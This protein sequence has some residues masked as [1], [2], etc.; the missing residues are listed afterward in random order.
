[1]Y[2]FLLTIIFLFLSIYLN[3]N[4][5]KINNKLLLFTFIMTIWS[6]AAFLATNDL[7]SC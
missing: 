1:M 7:M 4:E 3:K 6:F 5:T 2:W